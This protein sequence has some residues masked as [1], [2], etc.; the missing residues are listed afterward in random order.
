MI[1]YTSILLFIFV[2]LPMSN[3]IISSS[4]NHKRSKELDSYDYDYDYDYDYSDETIDVS[5]KGDSIQV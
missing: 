1:R 3:L 5:D 4:E 2:L